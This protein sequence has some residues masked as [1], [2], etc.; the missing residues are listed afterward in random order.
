MSNKHTPEFELWSNLGRTLLVLFGLYGLMM[1]ADLLPDSIR[2]GRSAYMLIYCVI[3]ILSILSITYILKCRKLKKVHRE[4]ID[5]MQI[6]TSQLQDHQIELDDISE[7]IRSEGYTPQN[8]DDAHTVFFN[9]SGESFEVRYEHE[10][11]TIRIHYN[12]ADEI[13]LD[14]LRK[15]AISTEEELYLIKIYF[16]TY[17][18]GSSSIVFEVPLLISSAKEL[19]RYFPRCLNLLLTSINRHREIYTELEKKRQVKHEEVDPCHRM[20]DA[21]VVS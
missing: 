18:D 21:K 16:P 2:Y 9:I 20:S 14:S 8:G 10:R 12:L 19:T 7:A 15:A 5:A 11:L 4:E 13:S 17:E 1:I 6:R 3:G